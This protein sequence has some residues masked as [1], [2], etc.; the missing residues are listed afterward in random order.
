[1]HIPTL[2]SLALARNLNQSDLAR[3]AGVT[4]QAV[5]NWFSAGVEAQLL[6]G[7]LEKLAGSLGVSV[8]VLSHPLPILSDANERKRW[9][10]DLLW[11]GLY[12]N[13]EAFLSGVIRGQ[14]QAL[15]RLVQVCGL[16][17]SQKIAGK[18]VWRKFP[19]YKALIHPAYRRQA[20]VV[21][22][23]ALSLGHH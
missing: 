3:A 5:S 8:E 23:T 19:S 22:K 11:D 10:T 7:N 9:E 16:Y 21:W 15:A 18:Q 17:M 13:L 14:R 20:E 2:K 12:P 4:R 1:V 6:S